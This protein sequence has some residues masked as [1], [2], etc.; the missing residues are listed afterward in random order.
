MKKKLNKAGVFELIYGKDMTSDTTIIRDESTVGEQVQSTPGKTEQ[1]K[2]SALARYVVAVRRYL[3]ICLSLYRS[4]WRCCKRDPYRLR[5][6]RD[7]MTLE[8][9]ITG[10]TVHVP[11]EDS[12]LFPVNQW[13]LIE[14]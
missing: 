6:K 14:L 12:H 8:H 10:T 5:K 13:T 4:L 11:M 1:H 2:R 7:W 3:R 9:R